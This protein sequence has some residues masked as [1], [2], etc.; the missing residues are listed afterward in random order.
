M[1][2]D[3]DPP[4]HM[5]VNDFFTKVTSSVQIKF[6]GKSQNVGSKIAEAGKKLLLALC[7]ITF[8]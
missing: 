8:I 3:K 4:I 5:T 7:L 6:L 1:H 2:V